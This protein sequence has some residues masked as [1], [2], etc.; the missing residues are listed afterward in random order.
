MG[1]VVSGILRASGDGRLFF[2][3]HAVT[4]A[5]VSTP[6]VN[7]GATVHIKI[8]HTKKTIG[9]SYLRIFSTYS[10]YR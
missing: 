8:G 9:G 4:V 7:S 6:Y 5:R 2:F 10:G 3:R 1:R